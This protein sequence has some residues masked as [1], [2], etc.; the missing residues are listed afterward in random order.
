[1]TCTVT[2]WDSSFS[3]ITSGKIWIEAFDPPSRSIAKR[4]NAT[5]PS[6]TIPTGAHG[7]VLGVTA[8]D[9]FDVI[10]HTSGTKYAPPVLETFT[11][12][13]TSQLDVVL[14]STAAATKSGSSGPAPTSP[15]AVKTF[16]MDQGWELEAKRAIRTVI[17]T[18]G[19]LKR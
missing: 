16:I 18:A 19:Y 9:I 10:V 14:F 5:L 1:M 11:G 6:G 8:S 12:H 17:A 2:I 3:A 13:G 4:P 15:N 7:A